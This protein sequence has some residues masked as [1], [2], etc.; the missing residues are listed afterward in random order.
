MNNGTYWL[1][2]GNYLSDFVGFLLNNCKL[3]K[4]LRLMCLLIDR[5]Y[6]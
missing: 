4:I 2:M 6:F 3:A 5:F 1:L